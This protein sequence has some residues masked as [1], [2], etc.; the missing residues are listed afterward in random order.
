VG[1]V[2]D[3]R[4]TAALAASSTPSG[5]DALAARRPQLD[6]SSRSAQIAEIVRDSILDGAL[7]PGER[8]SEPDI[9]EA[10][11]VSRNTLREAFRSLADQRLAVHE[12][13]RGMFVRVPGRSDVHE[14]YTCRR[15][16]EVAAV[17]TPH[18]PERLAGVR[19]AVEAAQACADEGDWVGVGT[20]DVAFHKEITALNGSTRINEFMQSVWNELRLVFHVMGN[21]FTFHGPYLDRNRAI[22]EVLLQQRTDDAVGMLTDYLDVAE[23]HILTSYPGAA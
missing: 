22:L 11:G 14:L 19:A 2:I 17:R 16:I 13:N 1:D 18:D 7:R 21:P 6:R 3:P 5:F 15:I 10:L 8:L 20:A 4:R 23:R 9:C 12:L